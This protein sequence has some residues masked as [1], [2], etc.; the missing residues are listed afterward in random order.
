MSLIDQYSGNL[1]LSGLVTEEEGTGK[2]WT[3]E[4]Q[5]KISG[6]T[7]ALGNQDSFYAGHC[8]D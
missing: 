2:V 6:L 8:K 3:A 4:W 5:T 7:Q 1:F